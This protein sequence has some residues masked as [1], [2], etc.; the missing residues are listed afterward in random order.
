[1]QNTHIIDKKKVGTNH[2]A[3]ASRSTRTKEK[4]AVIWVSLG[5]LLVI[6]PLVVFSGT[7]ILFQVRQLNL[8]NVT[9]FDEPV[10][11]LSQDK[12]ADL[13]DH[14]WNH[15]RQIH[16][17][18]LDDPNNSVQVTPQELGLWVDAVATA[19]RAFTIGR[20][21]DPF[22]DLI[23]ALTGQSR[24]IMPVL[25]F[26]ETYARQTLNALAKDLAIPAENASIV[27]QEGIWVALPGK[28]GRVVDIDTTLDNLV[29][30]AFPVLLTGSADLYL[31]SVSPQVIDLAPL[32][33]QIKLLVQQDLRMTA[34][35]PITDQSFEWMVP[36]EQKTAWVRVDTENQDIRLI[37]SP[38]DVSKLLTAWAQDLGE[39]RSFET[40]IETAA[41]INSWQNGETPLVSVIHTPTTY[42][43]SQ[44]KSLWSISLKLGM[45]MWYIMDANPG[46]SVNNLSAGMSL[47]I[48]S[49]N[50]LLPLPVV[51]NKRIVINISDQRMTVYENGQVRNTHIVS[52]GVSDS[53]TM[54]GIFQVQTHEINAY[55]SNWDLYMPHFLGIY[56]AWP[57][58]MNGIH[59]LPLLSN[60]HRLW[61]SNLGSPAS[62]GC[63]ILD[64]SAAEDLFY[65]ADP[66]V[67]VEIR[68]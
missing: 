25:Y 49:K 17:M 60:G 58:F 7:L 54:A 32:L 3:Q 44:E 26:D 24:I 64:L 27:F 39:N 55:A 16:L 35:D 11:L 57:G 42:Q 34:Y 14:T 31:K 29:K 50:I 45:P 66:G 6:L 51:P 43:V 9:I 1:M 56:E 28:E 52:T 15:D 23:S 30:H 5:A 20:S 33:D 10:G 37:I 8:P 47:T 68:N 48:P 61:A 18:V 53:P 62:Y 12:T 19:E 46:L 65:W 4:I 67:V 21:S 2:Q 63:I 36:L 40:N 13:I 38:E 59:G 41:I 22:N